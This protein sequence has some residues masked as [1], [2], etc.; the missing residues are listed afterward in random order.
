MAPLK[1]SIEVAEA[2]LQPP[3]TATELDGS[4]DSDGPESLTVISEVKKGTASIPTDDVVRLTSN[5][6]QLLHRLNKIK[7]CC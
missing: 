5:L 1:A 4:G 3:P 7:F 2:L 6:L